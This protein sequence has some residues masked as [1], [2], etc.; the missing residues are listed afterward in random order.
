MVRGVKPCYIL[1]MGSEKAQKALQREARI[2]REAE[3]KLVQRQNALESV[4]RIMTAPEK[5]LDLVCREAVLSI[6]ELLN[7]SHVSVQRSSREGLNVVARVA[8]GVLEHTT[9]PMIENEFC[10]IAT[11]SRQPCYVQ[12][13][14]R[15][16]FP[17]DRYLAEH[18][19]R[20]SVV[21]PIR[22][23]NTVYG[24]ICIFDHS[25]RSF[26]DYELHLIGIFASAIGH[27]IEQERLRR[28]LLESQR[29]T[30]IGQLVSGV[31][32]EVRNPLNAI[33]SITEALYQD[34]REDIEHR[35]LLDHIRTQV[36]RLSLLMRDLLDLGKP[37][38]PPNLRRESLL[39]ICTTA[40]HLWM[41]S[42]S[43]RAHPVRIVNQSTQDPE[44]IADPER[45]QQVFLNLFEN[46]A[47]HSPA[48]SELVV[49]IPEQ[50]S[51]QCRVRVIDRGPGI[52]PGNLRR[53]FEP[54]FTTRRGGTGLGL[55]IVRH[56]VETHGGGILIW[57]NDPQPGCTVEVNLPAAPGDRG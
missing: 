14:L 10:R 51:S 24:A 53:V 19:I 5:T 16:R 1:C 52:P 11:E 47:Q 30:V 17:E 36:E 43:G 46:G 6:S 26:S 38:H 3:D 23:G 57:N 44:V 45:L 31:A 22:N 12:S 4:Y 34:L 33:L 18:D 40:A 29:L 54:F 15:E 56:I 20:S 55:S 13:G 27:E 7:V 35:P 21:V 2:H 9:V 25:E 41:Q 37:V 28:E 50:S 32:H 49:E 8:D 39:N 42:P 48:G